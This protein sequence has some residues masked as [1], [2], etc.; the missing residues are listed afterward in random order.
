MPGSDIMQST[1]KTSDVSLETFNESLRQKLYSFGGIEDDIM[2]KREHYRPGGYHP[3]QLGDTFAKNRYRVIH[4][5]GHGGFATVWLCHDSE[6]LRY[7][8]LKVIIA[9]ASSE[10]CPELR[11]LRSK[12]LDF[13]QAGGDK[14]AIPEDHFWING[15]NGKHLCLVLPLLGPQVSSIWF[16]QYDPGNLPRKIALQVAQGIEFLHSNGICHG[17]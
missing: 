10:N 15:P 9:V 5:L 12:G 6:T 3:V 16:R 13:K 4:K 8:A 14:I 1:P 7:V 11:V 2:E 17:G